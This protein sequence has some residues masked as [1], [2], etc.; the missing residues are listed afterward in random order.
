MNRAIDLDTTERYAYLLARAGFYNEI[1]AF[2]KAL[3]DC[4]ELLTNGP[5]RAVVYYQRG[6]ARMGLKKYDEA[7]ADF[8]RAIRLEPD[9]T[10]AS[11]KLREA[12]R[13]Q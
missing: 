5:D 6:V 1:K 10:E 12:L 8:T 3:S 9:F 4:E 11:E 7:V 2:D 13:E